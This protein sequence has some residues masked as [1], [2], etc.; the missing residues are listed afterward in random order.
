MEGNEEMKKNK[1]AKKMG[2]NEEKERRNGNSSRNRKG[3]GG[4]AMG[5]AGGRGTR[6]G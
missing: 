4:R 1:R 6:T 5:A 3:V 2:K